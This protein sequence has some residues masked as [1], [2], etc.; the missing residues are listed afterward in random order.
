MLTR[1]CASPSSMSSASR[2]SGRWR[3]L[4]GAKLMLYF[5]CNENRRE[6][7]RAHPT[8]NGIDFLEVVDDPA[9]PNAERQ[10]ALLVR[11]LKPSQLGALTVDNIRF[12]GGERIRDVV[13]VDVAVDASNP[14]VL[15]VKVNQ[16]GDFSTYTL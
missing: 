1:P 14:L 6:L 2:S 12:E 8:L 9:L 15:A 4:H 10:R 11:F 3:S 13:A 16:P 7:V 5:C